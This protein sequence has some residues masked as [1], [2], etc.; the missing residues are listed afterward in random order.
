MSLLPTAEP[1]V[2]DPAIGIASVLLLAGIVPTGS[3]F[4]RGPAGATV[5]VGP[6]LL[7]LDVWLHVLGYGALAAALVLSA[8]RISLP[9]LISAVVAGIAFGAAV[10]LLQVSLSFRTGSP[11]DGLATATGAVLG[12]GTARVVRVAN[13][14]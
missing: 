6:I 13:R 1:G 7:G 10:E 5:E 8:D 2:S 4:G 12:A 11:I 14:E 3:L 9:V